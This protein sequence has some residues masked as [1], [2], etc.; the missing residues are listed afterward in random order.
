MEK[1]YGA[2]NSVEAHMI[3]NLLEQA[4]LNGQIE[5]EYLQGGVGEL[6]AS[7]FI[8]VMVN[9]EDVEKAQEIIKKW[10]ESSTTYLDKPTQK[11][12]KKFSTG[13]FLLGG[14]LFSVITTWFHNTPTYTDGIDYNNDGILDERWFYRGN[15]FL[16][17]EVDRNLDGEIDLIHKADRKGLIANSKS[18]DDYN[19]SFETKDRY[20]NGNIK[21][22]ASDTTGDG[23]A[24]QRTY[25]RLRISS[26]TDYLDATSKEVV[27]REHYDAFKIT[28]AEYDSDRDGILDTRYEFDQYGE[29]TSKIPIAR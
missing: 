27:K 20:E 13:S 15:V 18:D 14:F 12:Q 9:K 10:D 28:H 26:S 16:K 17:S 6:A 1:V 7:D 3:L 25:Y 29:L 24:D 11:T 4:G 21:L 5:G 23:F 8:R 2:S 19:G 22:R